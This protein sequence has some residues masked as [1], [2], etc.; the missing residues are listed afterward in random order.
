MPV[1][2]PVAGGLSL[3]LATPDAVL[4][5]AARLDPAAI[6]RV[7]V[8]VRREAT[9]APGTFVEQGRRSNAGF[10]YW[11]F[12]NTDSAD[13]A[14]NVRGRVEGVDVPQR[15]VI[16]DS[17]AVSV[18]GF[19]RRYDGFDDPA[20]PS[21]TFD[22]T[23][24]P[25]LINVTEG[26]VEVALSEG[27]AVV[28]VGLDGFVEGAPRTPFG[29]TPAT[30]LQLKLAEPLSPTDDYVVAVDMA[31]TEG[32][33]S[34]VT[35]TAQSAPG[36]LFLVSGDLAFGAIVT[37]YTALSGV[38][39]DLGGGRYRLA[40]AAAHIDGFPGT[41]TFTGNIEVTLDIDGKAT[42]DGAGSVLVSGP[43]Q[44]DAVGSNVR[45]RRGQIALSQ[46]GAAAEV[47][48]RL[49]AGFGVGTR[50]GSRRLR[51]TLSKTI[52]LGQTLAPLQNEEF[53]N[54]YAAEPELFPVIERLPQRFSTHAIDWIVAAG[55]FEF[56]PDSS[57]YE[58][59]VELA[60]NE[61]HAGDFADAA[62]AERFSNEGYHR[63]AAHR[64]GEVVRVV[65]DAGGRAVA[66]AQ[67]DIAPGAFTAHF[68]Q[69]MQIG[70]AGAGALEIAG[71]EVDLAAS[72]LNGAGSSALPYA[73]GCPL[74][75]GCSA[76]PLNPIEPV[77]FAP[78][79]DQWG[80]TPDGGLRAE[81]ATDVAAAAVDLKWGAKPAPG[82]SIAFTHQ[83]DG[84]TDGVALVAGHVLAGGATLPASVSHDERPS[85]LLFSGFGAPGDPARVERP[86][87]ARYAEGFA[88]YAG[89][90]FRV[91]TDAA[92]SGQS[93]IGSS[94]F[95]PVWREG[96]QQVLHSPRRG[97]RNPR[98]HHRRRA[99][100]PTG[101]TVTTSRSTACA[102]PISTAPTPNPPLPARS[103]CPSRR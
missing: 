77:G 47:T 97:Q 18:A 42:F 78:A 9:S 46:T 93:N 61:L 32:D 54:I 63:H 33:G 81:G 88:D 76:P 64:A 7:E 43:A 28:P 12:D 19:L 82:G 87:D 26:G 8:I 84:L 53:T 102:S 100:D 44:D 70:W 103:R 52:A 11:H 65:A 4:I 56:A 10:N 89:I 3:Q 2:F 74:P 5:P 58:R 62:A 1:A 73:Q 27:A 75:D 83:V 85:A 38:P 51:G 66:D 36:S 101:A 22:V 98:R 55:A 59:E 21:G 39:L 79:A 95:R 99:A 29:Q 25:R 35:A 17:L 80:F 37:R 92:F 45:F 72:F 30:L 48:V 86:R 90:N 71:G 14:D 67:F 23:F 13:L 49:P 50:A 34:T 20:P 31:W 68:P 24:T 60:T 91:G 69:G 40:V 6:V 94:Q 57:A 15:L 96:D 41:H 16:G